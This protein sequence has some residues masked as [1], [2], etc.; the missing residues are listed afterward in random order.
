MNGQG[1]KYS[2]DCVLSVVILD[3]MHT[4]FV[5]NLVNDIFS[6][7]TKFDEWTSDTPSRLAS[8]VIYVVGLRFPIAEVRTVRALW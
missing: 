7:F 1:L 2:T 4:V 8:T 6:T 5:N 3:S